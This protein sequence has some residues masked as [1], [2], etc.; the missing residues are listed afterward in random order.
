MKRSGNPRQARL[1]SNRFES[2]NRADLSQRLV[3]EA[4]ELRC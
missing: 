4:D 2:L 1:K 3:D